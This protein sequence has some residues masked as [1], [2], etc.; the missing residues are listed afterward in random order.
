MARALMG[1]IRNQHGMWYVQRKVPEHLQIAVACLQDKGKALLR[2]PLLRR[3]GEPYKGRNQV[4]CMEHNA[5]LLPV[6][7]GPEPIRMLADVVDLGG[8]V[9]AS[10]VIAGA[11]INSAPQSSPTT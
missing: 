2:H 7:V 4:N 10:S 3:W 8:A 11:P 9:F 5:V 6:G 1:L